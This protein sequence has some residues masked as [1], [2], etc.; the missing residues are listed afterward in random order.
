MSLGGARWG[1]AKICFIAAYL[2][3]LLRLINTT[4]KYIADF[5]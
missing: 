1:F 5:S 2:S 4:K 3:D